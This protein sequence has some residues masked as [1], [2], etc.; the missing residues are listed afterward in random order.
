[1]RLQSRSVFLL[2]F[3]ISYAKAIACDCSPDA[4]AP[5]CQKIATA[6]VVF[7]G[8]VRSIEP[9]P[10]MPNVARFRVYRFRVQT[11]YKGLSPGA[12]EV[13]VNPD[14]L[15]SCHR[16]YNNGA[17]YIVFG[18]TRGGSDEILSGGCHGSRLVEYA[19]DDVRFLEAYRNHRAANSVFGRV[20]QWGDRFGNNDRDATAPVDGATVTLQS[21]SKSFN[22]KSSSDGDFRFEGLPSGSYGLSA[23]LEPYVANTANMLVNV[24]PIGCAEAFPILS[25]QASITGKLTTYDGKPAAKLRVELLR[26]SN[27]GNWYSTSQFFNYSGPDGGFHFEDLPDGDYLLGYE[28]WGGRPSNNWAHPTR[29]YPGVPDLE[30]AAVIHLVPHANIHDVKFALSRPDTP[31][32]IRVVVVWPDDTAPAG[33]LLQLFDG[34]ELLTNVGDPLRNRPAQAHNGIIELSCFAERT[35]DL[36]VRYWIDDLGGPVPHDQQ[37]IARSEQVRLGPGTGPATIKLVLTRTL[38]SDEDR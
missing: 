22:K 30:S 10:G 2:W 19:P 25:A 15:T 1:M 4:S 5:A 17:T 6:Q 24:L 7:I 12:T 29:Y 23:R 33:N 31:R 11:A 20:L 13:V 16:E 32:K 34:D 38:M 3:L 28:I 27:S 35:Y 18:T 36:H 8:T 37:R 14:N 21:G 26:K 9:D